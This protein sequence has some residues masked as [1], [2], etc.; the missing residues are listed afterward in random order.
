MIQPPI[1]I[2]HV[3]NLP[4]EVKD[5]DVLNRGK[6][7]CG[8]VV[9]V[10]NAGDVFKAACIV[11]EVTQVHSSWMRCRHLTKG[12]HES[13]ESLF[14]YWTPANHLFTGL[15][16]ILRLSV[17]PSLLLFFLNFMSRCHCYGIGRVSLSNLFLEGFFL[18][19]PIGAQVG[20]F[21]WNHCS[22]PHEGSQGVWQAPRHGYS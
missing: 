1:K 8:V 2:L 10:W 21:H 11:D 5:A 9:S 4:L 13:V 14:G 15:L 19:Y 18:C 12:S 22:T 6:K 3:N 17:F 7:F 16:N 20:G